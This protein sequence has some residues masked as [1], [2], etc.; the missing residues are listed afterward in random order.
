MRLVFGRPLAPSSMILTMANR[1]F[2]IGLGRAF[3]GALIFSLP[4]LMTMEMWWLGFTM[5]KWKLAL[6]LLLTIPLLI[7]L[8]HYMGFEDT[9]GFK[10]DALDAFVA[11]AVGFFCG[12][13]QSRTFFGDRVRFVGRRDYRK[14]IDPSGPGQYR[15]HVCAKRTGRA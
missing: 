4:M 12:R 15:R 6:L 3:G 9:F 5:E 1:L 8:S 11:L 13:R 14:D 7:G 10:D 2:L